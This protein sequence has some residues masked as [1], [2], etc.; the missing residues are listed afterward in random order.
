METN[1]IEY[2]R[3]IPLSLCPLGSL[4]RSL[5]PNVL[6]SHSCWGLKRNLFTKH[7]DRLLLFLPPGVQRTE[8]Q[9]PTVSM[10]APRSFGSPHFQGWQ[11]LMNMMRPHSKVSIKEG[12]SRVTWLVKFLKIVFVSRTLYS[13]SPWHKDR[14]KSGLPPSP[15]QA[16]SVFILLWG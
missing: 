1:A 12:W 10:I 5:W 11:V 16:H 13:L 3:T 2:I 15:P 14:L 6:C 7:S 8:W 4:V 9:G